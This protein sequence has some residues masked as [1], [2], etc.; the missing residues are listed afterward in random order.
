MIRSERAGRC[1]AREGG[2]I[3]RR[4]WPG[5]WGDGW[6]GKGTLVQDAAYMFGG[7]ARKNTDEPAQ[8]TAYR[9]ACPSFMPGQS[10]CYFEYTLKEWLKGIANRCVV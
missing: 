5:E 10:K 2:E 1:R 7:R 8:N 4:D 3:T 9:N 6:V